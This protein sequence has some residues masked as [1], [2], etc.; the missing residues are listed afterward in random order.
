MYSSATAVRIVNQTDVYVHL[1]GRTHIHRGT[2]QSVH[3]HIY[4]YHMHNVSNVTLYLNNES[5]HRRRNPLSPEHIHTV[6]SIH[7]ISFN[8]VT[9]KN[10]VGRLLFYASC[11]SNA[12]R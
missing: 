3:V 1:S 7:I 2:S 12:M 11:D 5:L 9:Q 6:L 8:N 10:N 4:I